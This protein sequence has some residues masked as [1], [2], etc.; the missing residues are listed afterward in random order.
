MRT[1]PPS[2][3]QAIDEFKACYHS[4]FRQSLSDEEVQELAPRCRP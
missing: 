4:E 2:R 3:R 1:P